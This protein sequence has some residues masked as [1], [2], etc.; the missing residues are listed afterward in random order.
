MSA[1]FKA[2][3]DVAVIEALDF[4]PPC[5]VRNPSA[6]W[7]ACDHGAN[8]F[9]VYHHH[10]VPGAT[11]SRFLCDVHLRRYQDPQLIATCADC[12]E[13]A[14]PAVRIIRIERIGA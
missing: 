1:G 6:G 14:N 11:K 13:V 12:G 2:A 7:T 8:W 3:E 4:Q 10:C 9:A 5:E